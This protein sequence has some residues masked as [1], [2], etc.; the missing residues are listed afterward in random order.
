M[1]GVSRAGISRSYDVL[2]VTD[3]TAIG[4]QSYTVPAGAIYLEIEMMGAGG[5]GGMGGSITSGRNVLYYGA[6]GGGGGGYLKHRYYGNGDMQAN[7]VLEF[8]VGTGGAGGAGG[9]DGSGG[10]AT[11]V[12]AHKRSGSTI[13]TFS[14]QPIAY[15]GNGGAGFLTFFS[16]GAGGGATNGNISTS[17]GDSGFLGQGEGFNTSSWGGTGGSDGNKTSTGLGGGASNAG[18]FGNMTPGN[19]SQPGGGGGGAG[20]G[21]LNNPTGGTGGAGQ[22]RVTAYG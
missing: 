9:G 2:S 21:P 11:K 14:P 16:D 18:S 4:T 12:I 22:V 8:E 3:I 17:S 13:Y 19:G 7:D 6:Q 15:G 10:F 5:G 20:N 1:I